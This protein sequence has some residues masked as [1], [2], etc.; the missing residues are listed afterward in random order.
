MRVFIF[1]TLKYVLIKFIAYVCVTDKT[2]PTFSL[3]ETSGGIR[4][5]GPCADSLGDGPAKLPNMNEVAR[6][7]P[8]TNFT[9]DLPGDDDGS[10]MLPDDVASAG[11]C[12]EFVSMSLFPL[13]CGNKRA[14]GDRTAPEDS[15]RETT[16]R[17]G[18]VAGGAGGAGGCG[19]LPCGEDIGSLL[20]WRF[21]LNKAAEPKRPASI[22]PRILCAASRR[23]GN[24]AAACPLIVIRVE[25][26]ES[27][28]KGTMERLKTPLLPMLAGNREGGERVTRRFSL[29]D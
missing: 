5:I 8:S 14:C 1:E 22:E 12:R 18:G 11:A 29:T 26:P 19:S 15:D 9:G 25:L 2:P 24:G 27:M 20:G 28:K 21:R 23:A 7:I 13:R 10:L 17:G 16:R 6:V 3:M 4:T